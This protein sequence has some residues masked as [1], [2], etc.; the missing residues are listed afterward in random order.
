M[1]K[2]ILYEDYVSQQQNI[3]DIFLNTKQNIFIKKGATGIGGTE[4]IIEARDTS[5]IVISP[6][7]GMIQGKE[8]SNRIKNR[9]VFYIYGGSKDN[10][11][12]YIKCKENKVVNTTPDQIVKLKTS[13]QSL[14]N[15]IINYTIFVDEIHQY[16]PDS[17]YR[18]N[19]EEFSS[20]IFNTWKANVI[21]S[22][23]TDNLICGT[24]LD[25]PPTKDFTCY[26]IV[27]QEQN[28][29]EIEIVRSTNYMETQKYLE[30]VENSLSNNRKLLIATNNTKIH[31][32]LSKIAG[33]ENRILNLVGDN[34][35][36]KLRSIKDKDENYNFNDIDIILISS[37]YFAGF[38]IPLEMDILIDTNPHIKT[39]LL[40][41]NDIRQII[42]RPRK[43]VGRIVLFISY[44]QIDNEYTSYIPETQAHTTKELLVKIKQ[45]ISL[46]TNENW[47][48]TS[49]KLISDWTH[50]C[51]IF[52][53]L[54][55]NELLRYG[56]KPILYNK[57][58]ANDPLK[59]KSHP[60]HKQLKTLIEDIDYTTLKHDFYRIKTYLKN[61]E[62][63]VFNPDMLPYYY[64]AIKIKEGILEKP[65]LDTKLKPMYYY[66]SVNKHLKHLWE[67]NCIYTYLK[68]K[69]AYKNNKNIPQHARFTKDQLEYLEIRTYPTK[70]IVMACD[71]DYKCYLKCKEELKLKNIRLNE[72][73]DKKLLERCESIYRHQNTND[74][75]GY[76]TKKSLLELIG[77]CA[78]FIL[79]GGVEAYNF[80]IVKNRQFNPLTQIPSIL[81]SMLEVRLVE[82][83]IKSANPTF[84]DILVGSNVA[85]VVYE[86]TMEL[87]NV[88]REEAKRIYNTYLNNH[89]LDKNKLF[90][91]FSRI[92]Y[93]TDQAAELAYLI[94][95]SRGEIYNMTTEKEK[96]VIE[97]ISNYYLSDRVTRSFRFHDALILLE[98]ESEE[99]L[100]W[101]P[102]RIDK[103]NISLKIKLYN[104]GED[105]NFNKNEHY[106][107]NR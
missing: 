40:S 11:I 36:T 6:T 19:M 17:E 24:L 10:W 107:M 27:K 92:G 100:N 21:L 101:L 47:F 28:I 25:I 9:N 15:E 70:E 50:Y 7:V 104:T 68:T 54:L 89:R 88:N 14:F 2:V 63:G 35:Q 58:H 18:I 67:W 74:F 59:I 38:D 85:D 5:R 62:N 31:K 42:G 77:R 1:N 103:Y 87:F 82:I 61:V 71:G 73:E 57:T 34:I 80:P 39:G 43:G 22:S 46:I 105:I 72:K 83:D 3:L 69:W 48:E 99:V 41:I 4:A 20:I 29:K 78:L 32:D 96:E 90:G 45:R 93:T 81:R 75:K 44:K 60:F 49:Q 76:R 102:D 16:I 13:N 66:I 33:H 79:N 8:T 12:D 97:Y 106:V 94:P 55:N 64:C 30:V 37:K 23:A 91:Y 95:N 52:N 51:L 53:E 84:I 65:K 98:C 26:E 86:N 56:L